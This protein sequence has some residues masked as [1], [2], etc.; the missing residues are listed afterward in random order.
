MSVLTTS[1]IRQRAMWATATQCAIVYPSAIAAH[2][3]SNHLKPPCRPNTPSRK[4]TRDVH[5]DARDQARA[6]AGTPRF[7]KSRDERRKVEMR[8]VHL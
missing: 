8:F 1:C 4:V 5:E 3:H 7:E 6:L 2:V